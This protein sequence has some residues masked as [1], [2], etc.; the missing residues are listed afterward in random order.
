MLTLA[1]LAQ[2]AVYY[3]DP[4]GKFDCFGI[5]ASEI[6][7][8]SRYTSIYDVAGE[9]GIKIVA[10]GVYDLATQLSVS[11]TLQA[12]DP[13]PENTILRG[14]GETNS[15]QTVH[16]NANSILAGFTIE[17]CVSSNSTYGPVYAHDA[18]QVSNCVI[19]SCKGVGT[20]LFWGKGNVF[21]LQVYDCET[22]E[23]S[24]CIF[25]HNNRIRKN[26]I[27]RDN[28][29]TSTNEN[30]F[31]ADIT[32]SIHNFKFINNRAISTAPQ[33]NSKGMARVVAGGTVYDSYFENNWAENP[34]SAANGVSSVYVS[35]ADSV[36]SNC[37]IVASKIPLVRGNGSRNMYHCVVSNCV[38]AT[39]LTS[40]K[41]KYFNC[42]FVNNEQ[43]ILSSSK[44]WFIGDYYNCT[45]VKNK[46]TIEPTVGVAAG[47]GYFKNCL[48]YQNEPHDIDKEG[49][50]GAVSNCL[51]GATN[52]DATKEATRCALCVKSTNVKFNKGANPNL[53]YYALRKGSPAIDKGDATLNAEQKTLDLA[54]NARIVGDAIDIGCY[55][56]Y[57]TK[58]GFR[59]ILR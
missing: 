43:T 30:V 32:D 39:L 11:E 25:G 4:S 2:G 15:F 45:F 37:V 42:L 31:V 50:A 38:G 33:T 6:P 28:K 12:Y 41:I 9:K 27:I 5:D 20:K 34:V 19:R 55:E 29:L 54:G 1:S 14:T 7:E 10:P 23:G 40:T 22:S 57:P 56:W 59:I 13:N 24:L 35:L 18:A 36:L 21:D 8:S 26:V 3:V 17:N 58:D 46:N 52:A 51:Y 44:R 48:F 16:L 53:P 49:G 47:Y